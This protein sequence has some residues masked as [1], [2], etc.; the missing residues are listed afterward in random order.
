MAGPTPQ[1]IKDALERHWASSRQCNDWTKTAAEEASEDALFGIFGGEATPETLKTQ[2]RWCDQA[3]ELQ[4]IIDAWSKDPAVKPILDVVRREVE[5]QRLPVPNNGTPTPMGSAPP[6]V[7][8]EEQEAAGSQASLWERAKGW[9]G[10]GD[11]QTPSERAWGLVRLAAIVIGV[12]ALIAVAVKLIS[13][14]L[15]VQKQVIQTGAGLVLPGLQ[16]RMGA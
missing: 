16:A 6:I 4:K 8:E 1:Q 10:L 2:T 13:V 15:G 3:R 9:V 14:A 12:V 7:S 11:V 5:A